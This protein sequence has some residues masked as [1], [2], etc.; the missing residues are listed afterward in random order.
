[1]ISLTITSHLIGLRILLGIPPAP[2]LV[3]SEVQEDS[4]LVSTG[5]KLTSWSWRR[6]RVFRAVTAWENNATSARRLIYS[7]Y[8]EVQLDVNPEMEVM[9]FE[10]CHTKNRKIS[11]KQQV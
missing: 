6:L 7:L 8:M 2:F 3:Y 4:H 11:F 5:N 1:M 9:L 10:I